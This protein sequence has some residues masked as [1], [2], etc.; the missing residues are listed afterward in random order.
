MN[1]Y[2]DFLFPLGNMFQGKSWAASVIFSYSEL[3]SRYKA[4]I[5]RAHEK[6]M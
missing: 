3:D 1:F 2:V 4:R 5:L 6:H